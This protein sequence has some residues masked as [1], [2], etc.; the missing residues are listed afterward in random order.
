MNDASNSPKREDGVKP[1]FWE[2]PAAALAAG[3][4]QAALGYLA[5]DRRLVI[6]I[7]F[8]LFILVLRSPSFFMTVLDWDEG[9]YLLMGRSLLDGDVLYATIWDHKPPGIHLVYALIQLLLGDS[10]FALRFIACLAIAVTSYL[11][12][13]IGKII[14]GDEKIGLLAGIL[15]AVFSLNNEGLA[16]NTNAEPCGR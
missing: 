4:A 6:L 15:Y 8:I 11:L 9:I 1:E 5:H 12:F 7:F 13:E 10:I 2:A 14:S 3:K 16:A